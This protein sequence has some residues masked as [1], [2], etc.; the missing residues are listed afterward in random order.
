MKAFIRSKN[1]EVQTPGYIISQVY[2]IALKFPKY[3]CTTMLSGE[4]D[5][6]LTSQSGSGG[7]GQRED[8]AV[9]QGRLLQLKQI[10]RIII[11]WI[12]NK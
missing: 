1:E 7:Y 4:S 5:M 12:F 2:I 11:Q 3:A 6:H 10:A 8:A 9:M